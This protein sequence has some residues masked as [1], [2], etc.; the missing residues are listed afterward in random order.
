[1]FHSLLRNR[2]SIRQFKADKVEPEKVDLLLETLLR[3]PS[4]RS[5]N[6]WQFVAVDDPQLLAGLAHAKA[7][8]AEFLAGAPLAVVVCADP[9]RCDVWIEDC[10]IAAILLQLAAESLGLGSCWAQMRLRRDANDIDA[11]TTVRGDPRPAAGV[12]RPLHRRHRLPAPPPRRPSPRALP[13]GKI[14]RNRYQGVKT[15]L[16]P[17]PFTG[18]TPSAVAF[19]AELAENNSKDWVE[20]NRDRYQRDVL[21][22]MRALVADLAGA[23]LTLD[24]QLVTAPAIGKTISRLHRDTRFS[25]DKSP[26]RSNVWLVFR[27]P[28][29][30]WKIAPCFYFEIIPDSYR[31]GMGFYEAQAATMARLRAVIA[32]DPEAFRRAVAGIEE[33]F[34]VEGERYKRPPGPALPEDLRSWGEWKSFYLVCN[35]P[36]DERLYAAELADELREAFTRCLPLYRLLWRVVRG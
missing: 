5:R 25:R 20:A 26:Y 24:D 32:A 30:D 10:A 17:P 33:W 29:A 19:L 12:D 31:F 1:M 3:A 18:F 4:S 9:A 8:G 11:E 2:R 16:P 13:A 23:M 35:R 28:A 36:L 6:P 27:R 14:H 34:A 22:P 15:M 7:H 21:T